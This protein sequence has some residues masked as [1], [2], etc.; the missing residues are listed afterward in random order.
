VQAVDLDAAFAL[1]EKHGCAV[2]LRARPGDFVTDGALLALASPTVSDA[3]RFGDAVR[4]AYVIGTDR[5]PWQDAE[6]AI[7][8]LVEVALHALSPGINEP[9]TA[10]TCIDRLGQG[11]TRLLNRRIPAGVRTNAAG[12]VRLVAEAKSFPSLLAAA[13]DPITLYAGPNPAIYCRLLETLAGLGRRAY[14]PSERAAI[15]EHSSSIRATALREVTDDRARNKVEDL[16]RGV[17]ATSGGEH[18]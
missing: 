18:P 13:F 1:A 14:R 15:F 2:W 9:F 17:T 3:S 12:Q 8:Q 6:F 10:V 7:Q 5:T 4:Q 16:Y 11:L